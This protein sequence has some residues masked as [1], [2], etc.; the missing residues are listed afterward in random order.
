MN[1]KTVRQ[2]AIA[3]QERRN[4]PTVRQDS[5]VVRGRRAAHRVLQAPILLMVTA[6][7]TVWQGPTA[8]RGRRAA[9]R[10][11]QGPTPMQRAP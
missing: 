7:S 8:V 5:G 2:V 3:T 1:V 10:V 11:P 4:A 9:H 6:V